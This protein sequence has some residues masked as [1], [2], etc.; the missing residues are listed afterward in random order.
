MILRHLQHVYLPDWSEAL[1]PGNG[2]H[3][4]FSLLVYERLSSGRTAVPRDLT[5]A[6]DSLVPAPVQS[7]RR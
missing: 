1:H 7:F 4:H 2:R 3:G 5:T 6:P